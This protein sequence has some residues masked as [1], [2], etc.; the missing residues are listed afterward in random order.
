MQKAKIKLFQYWDSPQPPQ[1]VVDLMK[2]WSQ[3]KVFEY[4]CYSYASA[5]NLINRE[6]PIGY[7][8]AFEKCAVPAMQADFFRY[9]VLSVF[10]GI[11]VDADTSNGGG[12]EELIG[13]GPRGTL[14]E[15]HNNIANDFMYFS[16]PGDPLLADVIDCVV[17]NI[18]GEVSQNVWAVTG[19]GVLTGLYAGNCG[20]EL[21]K[22]IN[23]LSVKIV[24]KSVLFKWDMEYKKTAVDWR[25]GF[26]VGIK[27]IYK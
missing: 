7:S 22:D 10:G 2:T 18:A 13:D 3:D 23:I 4:K 12:V 16:K 21:F 6:F 17:E 24:R 15:R 9:C 8:R 11:Y 14:M 25:V 1:E 19:P 5:L 27:N 20:S 26:G